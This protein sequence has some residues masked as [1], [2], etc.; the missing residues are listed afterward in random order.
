MK[1]FTTESTESTEDFEPRMNTNGH[2]VRSEARREPRSTGKRVADLLWL[3]FCGVAV[4]LGVFMVTPQG[5]AQIAA[6]DR[7]MRTF[8]TLADATVSNM[9]RSIYRTIYIR[10]YHS[11][12]DGGGGVLHAV[13]DVTGTNYGTKIFSGTTGKSWLRALNGAPLTPKMFGARGDGSTDD[14]VRLQSMLSAAEGKSVLITAGTYMTGAIY[15]TNNT[16]ITGTPGAS[17]KHLPDTTHFTLIYASWVTNVVIEGLTFDGNIANQATWNEHR[18]SLQILDA[19]LVTA[20]R[21]IFTNTIGDGIYVSHPFGAATP[22]IGSSEFWLL[23]NQ[24]PGTGSNRNGIS[25][26]N[27]RKGWVEGNSFLRQG[28]PGMP[29]AIDVEQDNTNE[30]NEF[31]TIARNKIVGRIDAGGQIDGQHA[32]A[33]ANNLGHGTNKTIR[34]IENDISGNFLYPIYVT[35][36]TN[37]IDT[38]EVIGNTIRDLVYSGEDLARGISLAG[39]AG[40]VVGNRVYNVFGSGIWAD[41]GHLFISGNI[42]SNVQKQGVVL[43]AAMT[44]SV[45]GNTIE[46]AGKYNSTNPVRGGIY[47]ET[48][49]VRYVGNII[50][51]SASTNSLYGFYSLSG[52]NNYFAGN[53]ISG[54]GTKNWSV[55]GPQQWGINRE[56]TPGAALDAIA[57]KELMLFANAAT[58]ER[59]KLLFGGVTS[60]HVMLVG[61]DGILR[62]E[63]A[64]GSGYGGFLAGAG[65]F[66]SSLQL[67][68]LTAN[69][70]PY[71]DGT[72]KFVSS[73]VTPT[74]LGHLSGVTAGLQ[75]QIDSKLSAVTPNGI[76]R[77]AE[78]TEPATP[79]AGSVYVYAKNTGDIYIKNFSGSE[80][81]LTDVGSGVS[82]GDK[83]DIT[84]SSSGSVFSI[85]SGVVSYAKMQNVSATARIL[86]RKT[87]GAGVTEEL[88][89]SELFDFIGSAAQGDIIY[90][91][92]SGWARLPT[93]TAGQ[94]LESGGAGANLAWGTDD[95]G[96]GGVSDGDKGDITVSGTG[97]VFSLDSGVV[98]YAKMQDVSATARILGRKTAGAGDPEEMTLSELL[99]FIGSAAQ[100]DILYRGAS[101]WARLPAGSA[102]QVLESGGAGANPAWG[103][104]D[105]GGGG[106]SDGDKGDIVVSGTGTVFNIDANAVSDAKF[107]QSA[108]LSVVGRSA[109]STG[110]TADITAANDGEVL[111]RSGTALGFGTVAAGGIA[112]NAVTDGKLRDS[113][114]VS[115]IGRSANSS[116]D[117]ADIAAG[118]NGQVLMRS[119]NV[120]GFQGITDAQIGSAAAIA[121]SKIAAGTADH[122]VIN[123]GSGNLSSV[124]TTGSGNVMRTRTGVYRDIYIPAAAMTPIGTV[125]VGT[126]TPTTTTDG[127]AVDVLTF[128][129]GSTESAQFTF[130]PPLQSTVNSTAME[131]AFYCVQPTGTGNIRWTVEVG[132]REAGETFGNILGSA[133]GF[134]YSSAGAQVMNFGSIAGAGT[135]GGGWT[136]HRSLF[137]IRL[138]RVGGDALD[139]SS[140]D[141]HLF[142]VRLVFPENTTEESSTR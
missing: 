52:T 96:G 141:V 8:D 50:E 92:S 56:K 9:A 132:V 78:I 51:S 43:G 108:G 2:E 72:K 75:G 33:V 134:T 128:D 6:F 1:K 38:V 137:Y 104:D 102:G 119:N 15:V 76:V 101:G 80:R 90:R 34:V 118:A 13:D 87:A 48:F 120:V 110:N 4:L 12:D 124:A 21:N 89:L 135:I 64:D 40:A 65:E 42:I 5:Q 30:F 85:D 123:D 88:T 77:L 63:T 107:R 71:A 95:A 10:G 93:G 115:V 16:R 22:Y 111:R 142:G 7:W 3:G 18:H 127:M 112:D 138:S 53:Y 44:G 113:A 140:A 59:I 99:D 125:G 136:D 55:T 83:G 20:Q 84:V 131:I 61:Q 86:G 17:L 68:S 70:V 79:P 47:F 130:V 67:N 66:A 74:E 26:I 117:P 82:D 45:A 29:G 91:G 73:A 121:R 23:Y 103:T 35:G 31:L 114:A 19:G 58:S 46:D 49:G 54:V 57:N 97:T 32:I 126:F 28:R 122:A 62:V 39:V 81:N 60:G 109:N 133:Q 27:T 94:V 25:L 36:S 37:H 116:G 129:G 98:S 139:T 14:T 24:F 41:S 100:G 105:T 11:A 106:V 69:T